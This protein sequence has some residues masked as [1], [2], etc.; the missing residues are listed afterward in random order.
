MVFS[1]GAFLFIVLSLS[2]HRLFSPCRPAFFSVLCVQ[3]LSELR[4]AFRALNPNSL[5][6]E[7]KCVCDCVTLQGLATSAG[8]NNKGGPL[9]CSQCESEFGPVDGTVTCPVRSQH[10]YVVMLENISIWFLL[11]IYLFFWNDVMHYA[12]ETKVTVSSWQTSFVEIVS[13]TSIIGESIC[14]NWLI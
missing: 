4:K 10:H 11:F 6:Q 1:Q 5:Y 9:V 8:L 2:L 12:C 14:T 7:C 3:T 13:R